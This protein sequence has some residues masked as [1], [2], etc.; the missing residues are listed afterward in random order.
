M[1]Q[2]IIGRL[3]GLLFSVL[4][5]SLILFVSVRWLPGTPWN[6][7]DFPLQ[8]AAR[9][10]MLRKYGLDKPV[11]RQ[12]T[13]YLWNL[14]HLDLGNSF[15]YR[16]DSVWKTIQRA[17]PATAKIG[18]IT[19]AI[20]LLVGM[21]LGILA[22]L[23]Q[24]TIFDYAVTLLATSGITV[25][26]FAVAVWLVLFVAIYLDLTPTQGWGTWQHMILPVTAYTLAPLGLVARFTRVSMLE[27]M[28]SDYVRTARAKGLSESAVV[29]RHIFKNALIPIITLVGPLVPNLMT[30]SIFIE[31]TFGI[32]G[33]G[34]H[35]V[36]SIFD[37]DYPVIL[38]MFM[39]VAVLFGLTYVVSDIL[40]TWAD[41]RVRLTRRST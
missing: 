25:P 4:A 11:W 22:S 13:I 41:P 14:A 30:G 27:A 18:I 21:T 3:L 28:R 32:P 31:A 23:R 6:E 1:I 36:T 15:V 9:E 2:Y 35:F 26:N 33:L 10:N 39:L 29:L 8:G 19:V 16:T 5:I 17:W 37:R 20:A 12:Y 24:N 38:G 40:Y 34:R 7:Q